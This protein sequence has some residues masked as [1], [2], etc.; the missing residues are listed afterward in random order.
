MNMTRSATERDLRQ[1][2]CW[3]FTGCGREPGG[4]RADDLGVCPAAADRRL[5]GIND[6][7]NGGRVCWM[8]AGTFS[9]DRPE[10]I[11]AS[12][13]YPCTV[14][15]FYN[16]VHANSPADDTAEIAKRLSARP[17]LETFCVDRVLP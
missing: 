9:G 6:G 11:R 13:Q 2:N 15:A 3:E 4:S 5:D 16:L 7:I 10:C 1:I 17:S 8:I 14:C 12:S